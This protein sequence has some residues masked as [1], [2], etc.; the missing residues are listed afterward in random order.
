MLNINNC[1]SIDNALITIFDMPTPQNTE[2]GCLLGASVNIE[3]RKPTHCCLNGCTYNR[4]VSFSTCACTEED[5][6][7]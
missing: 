7:W 3:R 2:T 5:F 4:E 6:E 1:A